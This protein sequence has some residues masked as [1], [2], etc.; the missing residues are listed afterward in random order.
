MLEIVPAVAIVGDALESQRELRVLRVAMHRQIH[1][2]AEETRRFSD[3]Q[4]ARDKSACNCQPKRGRL[5]IGGEKQRAIV[6]VHSPRAPRIRGALRRS[7]PRLSAALFPSFTD[8]IEVLNERQNVVE[9][10]RRGRAM[11]RASARR[12]PP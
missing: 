12:C 7:N 11:K 4:S 6:K 10:I 1:P 9:H 5:R 3:A 2:R 8:K